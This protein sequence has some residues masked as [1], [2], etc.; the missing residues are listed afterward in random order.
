MS[1]E[2]FLAGGVLG[3]PAVLVAVLLCAVLVRASDVPWKGKPYSQWDEN[4]IER[5][6]TD[7]PWTRTVAVNRTW[8]VFST[9]DNLQNDQLRHADRGLPQET[10]RSARNSSSQ[11]VAFH[12]DWGSARPMRA[13]AARRGILRGTQKGLNLEK[14]ATEPQDE[15]QIIVQAEDMQPFALHDESFFQASAFLWTKKNRQKFRASQVRYER[16][17]M[18]IVSAIFIFLKKTPSGDPVISSDEKSVTFTCKIE[19]SQLKA[20]FEPQKMVDSFGPTL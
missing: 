7:S 4:D 16:D 12:V 1:K 19:E 18:R 6:F 15:Y 13:A 17:G 8:S 14:Y 5:I 9:K 10:E 20:T 3:L 11:D 2:R